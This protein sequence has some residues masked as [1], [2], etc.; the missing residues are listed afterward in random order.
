MDSSLYPA[1]PLP[2]GRSLPGGELSDASDVRGAS[3]KFRPLRER[4]ES[5]NPSAAFLDTGTAAAH[6]L[7]T[8]KNFPME[9]QSQTNPSGSTPALPANEQQ[10]LWFANEVLPHEPALRSWLRARFPSLPDS[11]DVI[12]E[13]YVRLFRSRSCERITNAKSYLFSTARNLSVDLLRRRQV[14]PTV[15][16]TDSERSAVV[17]EGTSVADTV[18]SAQEVEILLSAIDALPDRCRTIMMMQKLQGL[19]NA[20]IAAQLNLSVNTVNAQLVIGLARCRAYLAARGIL[21]GKNR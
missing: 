7:S 15:S 18:S 11:D 10:R 12:Q 6:S 4:V 1:L 21:R 8:P 9:L 5:R 14:A 13:T 16:I 3:I 20:E 2:L 17:E 19:S